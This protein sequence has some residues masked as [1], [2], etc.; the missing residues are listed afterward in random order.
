M[1]FDVLVSHSSKDK[2]VTD[3]LG[4]SLL[5]FQRANPALAELFKFFFSS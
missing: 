2:L 3:E 4:Q 1:P 5:D